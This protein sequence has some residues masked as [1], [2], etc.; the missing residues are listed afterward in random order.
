MLESQ[1]VCILQ[2]AF[3]F[4]GED[5]WQVI[6]LSPLSLRIN[7]TKFK[8][9]VVTSVQISVRKGD[10]MVCLDLK[11]LLPDPDPS[12]QKTLLVIQSKAYNRPI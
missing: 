11:D 4:D 10:I 7:I 5:M 3:F 6:D 9:E 1:R 12:R 8:E 2:Q